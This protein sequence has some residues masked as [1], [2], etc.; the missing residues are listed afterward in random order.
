LGL[1]FLAAIR[2][3]LNALAMFHVKHFCKN[4]FF[5]SNNVAEI[6]PEIPKYLLAPIQ[7]LMLGRGVFGAQHLIILK[8]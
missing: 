5:R 8:E 1:Y 4:S 6:S 2:F 3:T 7:R